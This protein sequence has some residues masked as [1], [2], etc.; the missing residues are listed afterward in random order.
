MLKNRLQIA[1]I[2][3]AQLSFVWTALNMLDENAGSAVPACASRNIEVGASIV[4]MIV[5]VSLI[6]LLILGLL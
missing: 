5:F 1:K 2:S 3:I 6:I 4:R